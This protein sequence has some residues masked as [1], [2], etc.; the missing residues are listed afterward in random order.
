MLD[1]ED[2][3]VA[4]DQEYG[5]NRDC[6]DDQDDDELIAGDSSQQSNTF[7]INNADENMNMQL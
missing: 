5:A 2:V 4:D 3:D 6:E 7:S 1:D